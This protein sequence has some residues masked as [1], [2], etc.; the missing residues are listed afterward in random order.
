MLNMYLGQKQFEIS[1]CASSQLCH[2]ASNLSC[3]TS[4]TGCGKKKLENELM[5][6]F[7]GQLMDTNQEVSKELMMV[8]MANEPTQIKVIV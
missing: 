3:L 2:H 7:M 5:L 1:G 4:K 8:F 6:E